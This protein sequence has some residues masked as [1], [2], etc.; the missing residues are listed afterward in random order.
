MTDTRRESPDLLWY[1][2]ARGVLGSLSLLP[3]GLS[4]TICQMLGRLVYRRD[5]RHRRI[6]M[7]NL[8]LA[9][10]EKSDE[11]RTKV[12]ERSYAQIAGHVAELS[13]LTRVSGDDIHRRVNYEPGRGVENY[14]LARDEGRGV[15]FLTAH[16]SSWE[17]LPQ[18]HA[19]RERPLSFVVRPLDNPYLDGWMTRIR[20][21]FGNRVIP[22]QG[23]LREM[24]RELHRGEA[25]GLLVDQNVQEKDGV[26]A[27]LFGIPA[28][29][30]SSV[31]LLSMKTG[32]PVVPAFLV[33]AESRGRYRMRFY[34][35][36]HAES[37][38]SREQDVIHNTTRFNGFIEAVIRE[39]PHCW[40]WGHRRFRT[41]PDGRDLYG[42]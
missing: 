8:R 24:L 17:L 29:T 23:S 33:P 25:V 1:L 30:T 12:L 7:T 3:L 9:F 10:P 37:T 14:R 5:V 41:Q 40:L 2:A 11:W 27:P 15:L 13:R 32:A 28:C 20:T 35:P 22:K 19:L 6:G 18:A 34:P 21:R 4:T 38:G 16:I 36:L 42:I 31:A 26:Y 39:F